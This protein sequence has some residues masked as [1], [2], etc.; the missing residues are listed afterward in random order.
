[1][2]VTITKEKEAS[3]MSAYMGRQSF[4]EDFKL[5][6]KNGDPLLL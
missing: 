2:Y 5:E 6:G 1:M 3:P 4:I